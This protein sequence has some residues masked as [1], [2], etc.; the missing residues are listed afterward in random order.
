MSGVWSGGG[1][2]AADFSGGG[3]LQP[4]TV[5]IGRLK[6]ATTNLLFRRAEIL[7]AQLQ[8]L[9]APPDIALQGDGEIDC[10]RLTQFPLARAEADGDAAEGLAWLPDCLES[11]VRPVRAGR[12]PVRVCSSSPARG[13]RPRVFRWPHGRI[14]VRADAGASGGS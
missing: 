14:R 8:P 12:A 2:G 10:R 13:L 7:D 9:V 3:G 5:R 1:G 11:Q 4:A 6:S